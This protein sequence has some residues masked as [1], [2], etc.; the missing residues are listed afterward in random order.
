MIK[1][2]LTGN[3]T[4]EALNYAEERIEH[5]K[6]DKFQ[7]WAK[8]H[9]VLADFSSAYKNNTKGTFGEYLYEF[10]IGGK[11]LGA[12]KSSDVKLPDGSLVEVKT[13]MAKKPWFNQI[14][15]V[16]EQGN[17]K[18]FDYLAL[19][20]ISTEWINILQAPRMIG[21]KEIFDYCKCGKTANGYDLAADLHKLPDVF[22]LVARLEY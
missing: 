11:V 6:E 3:Q 20:I 12:G 17:K 19:V 22:R 14:K 9:P 10:V 16:D 15:K 2:W 18:H 7:E 5:L 4:L 21:N 1:N 13:S 8:C